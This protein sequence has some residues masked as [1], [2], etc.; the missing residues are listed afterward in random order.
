[1]LPHRKQKGQAVLEELR[2]ASG[3]AQDAGKEARV[4]PARPG[5]AVPLRRSGLGD[6]LQLPAG[7]WV[8]WD[9]T[10]LCGEGGVGLEHAAW[11]LACAADGMGCLCPDSCGNQGHGADSG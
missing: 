11:A 3:L 2:L 7:D 1:M 10:A 8:G 4:G 6:A 5:N 9:M